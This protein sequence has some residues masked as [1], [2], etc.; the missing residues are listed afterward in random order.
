MYTNF[1][2]LSFFLFF[3]FVCTCACRRGRKNQHARHCEL[4][5]ILEM[6]TDRAVFLVVTLFNIISHKNQKA[7]TLW[8]RNIPEKK[9]ER[10]GWTLQI[11][12]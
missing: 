5:A 10:I 2:P 9:K 1:N 7:S 11:R 8:T 3:F 12:Q 6:Y 4:V